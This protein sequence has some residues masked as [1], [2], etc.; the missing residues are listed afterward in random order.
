MWSNGRVAF[1]GISYYGMV[2][3]WAA[4]QR[5]PPHLTCVISYES[6]SS[7][8]QAVR[9]SGIYSHNFQSHWYQ[10]CVLPQQRG[11]QYGSLSEAELEANRVDFPKN[12]AAVEY[13]T[14]GIWAVLGKVR[15]LSDITVPFYL[16]GN[17]TN[18]E[19]HLPGNIRAFNAISSEHKWLEIHTGDHVAAYYAP[20]HIALQKKFLDFFLHEIDSGMLQVP[21]IRLAQHHGTE[22]VYREDEIAFP[23]PDAEYVPLYLTTN[24]Q[25]SSIRPKEEKVPFEY[26]GM[27]D[28]LLFKHESTFTESF[29][30]LGSPYLRLEIATEA[31]DMDLFIYLRALDSND[32]VISLLGNHGEPMDSFARGYFRL[33]HRREVEEGFEA[34]RVIAQPPFPKS[35]VIKGHI[36]TVTVPL[37]PTAFLFDK[38]R[39]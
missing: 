28:N 8:Y 16:A 3:Y 4:M 1:S 36:Y 14:E 35:E 27:K 19:L 29:E 20:E 25:L 13:P 34:E 31:E 12:M 32:E 26:Q 22:V 37:Y 23:P 15:K 6:N 18:A 11:K 24:G 33:S 5:P 21:R 10:N 38:G 9:R 39:N 17:W 7:K 2:G 30:I